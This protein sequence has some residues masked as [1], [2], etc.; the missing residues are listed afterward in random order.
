MILINI[1]KILYLVFE[2]IVNIII[3]LFMF[4]GLNINF[5]EIKLLKVKLFLS[6]LNE[7]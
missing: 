3:S 6:L 5:F 2:E 1:I 7:C 4:N